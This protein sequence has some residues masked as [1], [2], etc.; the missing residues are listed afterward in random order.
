[1]Y[2]NRFCGS[3][4]FSNNLLLAITQEFRWLFL[5]VLKRL[6][7]PLIN[8][9]RCFLVR[10]C[11]IQFT[12]YSSR[13]RSRGELAYYSTAFSFCQELFFIFLQFSFR[14]ALFQPCASSARI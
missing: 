9:P 14:F 10:F 6:N 3:N 13:R 12:R 4:H 7:N 2:L 8:C 1:L 5:I 11:V